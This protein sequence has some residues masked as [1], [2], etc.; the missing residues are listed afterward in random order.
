MN[1]PFPGGFRACAEAS[2]VA[3]LALLW[4]GATAL[5]AADRRPH[6]QPG[7]PPAE[8]AAL[9]RDRGPA[10]AFVVG[11]FESVQVNVD[12]DGLNV[13][14][15]AANEPTLAV[16]PLDRRRIAVGWRQFDSIAS[17]FREAGL[18]V[19]LDGGHTWEA[20]TT[21]G[22]GVFG[23]DPVLAAAHDG[24]FHYTTLH[25]DPYWTEVY[26]SLDDLAS[27]EAPVYAFGGDK[28]WTAVDRTQG[29]GRGHLYQAWDYAGCCGDDW[30]ARS[31]DGGASFQSPLPIA[32]QPFWG[33]TTVGPAGEVWVAGTHFGYNTFSAARSTNAQDPSATPSFDLTSGLNLGGALVFNAGSGPN[34]GGLLGQV[35][36]DIDRSAHPQRRGWIYVLATVDPFAGS[37]PHDV[38]FIRSTDGGLT[39]SAPVRVN[40]D[41]VGNGAWQWFGTMSVAPDGRI[42]AVWNDTR[43]AQP[44]SGYQSQLFYS[45]SEDGGSTWSPNVALSPPFDPHLGWPNQN[46]LGDYYG[47]V[48]DRV[49][50]DVIYAAT[51]GGEQNVF[52]LRIGDRDCNDNG[53]G[54]ATDIATGFDT[55]LDG[56]GIPDRCEADQDGDGAVDALDNCVAIPNRNQNDAD[57]NGAGDACDVF[58]DGFETGDSG[59]WSQSVP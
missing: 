3:A 39:W 42:D 8:A 20:M 52:Y 29:Q 46:K 12:A 16:S 33:T 31:I 9:P 10:A 22:D 43:N 6:E 40:D 30:F 38:H 14:G 13:T 58:S 15:D 5:P 36:I 56:S 25:A 4:L 26:R 35:W 32:T 45:Y 23:S 17:N 24:T 47:M 18:N 7:D 55:D 48:S 28:E 21:L 2:R 50:A 59:R 34:P 37:D 51:F 49:G 41:T 1:P 11:E 44:P 27:W 19:S 54:D 57:E 53:V